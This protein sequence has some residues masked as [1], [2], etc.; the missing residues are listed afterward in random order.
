MFTHFLTFTSS[1]IFIIFYLEKY[2]KGLP[3]IFHSLQPL[4]KIRTRHLWH[5]Q[6]VVVVVV[7][8]GGGVA[9]RHEQ[10]RQVEQVENGLKG[11]WKSGRAEER[12]WKRYKKNMFF[13]NCSLP[14]DTYF[15]HWL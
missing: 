15:V 3:L 12:R 14:S 8:G 5:R 6:D 13:C 2:Q 1:L 11:E 9:R 10:Q 4:W 7:G